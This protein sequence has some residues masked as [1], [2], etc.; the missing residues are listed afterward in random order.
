MKRFDYDQLI[1]QPSTHVNRVE[2]LGETAAPAESQVPVG[3]VLVPI[4]NP[5]IAA[6]LALHARIL[7]AWTAPAFCLN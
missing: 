6:Q 2:H 3:F 1:T 7:A 5:W 4:V